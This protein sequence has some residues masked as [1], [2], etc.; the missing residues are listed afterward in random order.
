VLRAVDL[1]SFVK[2]TGGRGLHVVVPIAPS[3]DWTDCLEFAR[4]FAQML[5]RRQPALFTERFARAGRQEKILIDYL[6]NNRTNTSVA[7]Y[8]TRA[9]PDAPVSTPLAWAELTASKPPS[10]FTMDVVR[11]RLGTLRADPWRDYWRPPPRI[12][13]DAIEALQKL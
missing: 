2:T 12:S 1:E 10:R 6:R 4:H 7:A 5:V 9:T 13:R 11:R 3:A 8:S